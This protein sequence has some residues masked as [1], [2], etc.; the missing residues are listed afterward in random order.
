MSILVTGASG[1]LGRHV[2]DSL[3]ARGVAPADIVAGV[4]TAEKGA[5][6][7]ELGVTVVPLDVNDPATVTAALAGVS[8]VLLISGPDV[9]NRV[10]GHR[11]VIEAAAAAGVELLV[12]T[13]VARATSFAWP[14][15]ESHRIT[16]EIIAAS[17]VPAVVLRNNWYHENQTQDVLGAAE[18]G[19]IA[20]ATGD[21][22]VASASR[23]DYAEAAAA[24]LTEDKHTG[25]I[26]ELGGDTAWTYDELAATAGEILGR[27]VRFVAQTLA[28]R[29]AT[30]EGF[31]LPAEVAAFVASIDE[32]IAGGVLAESDGTLSRLIGRPTTPLA[33]TLRAE[34]AAAR[35]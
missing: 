10:D 29:T 4:F 12:Y 8:R 7:R 32:G 33:E 21:A 30:L 5:P 27:E 11:T 26:Y 17:G 24:V 19:V 18:S 22:R 15:G 23:K 35:A 6:L 3:L 1:H 28:E 16:E 25:R 14:L 20:A 13:S 2:V 9:A 34:V 31:G